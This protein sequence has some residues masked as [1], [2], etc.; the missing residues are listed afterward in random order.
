MNRYGS[1]QSLAYSQNSYGNQ[2][3]GGRFGTGG[4][5]GLGMNRFNSIQK[6]GPN[7]MG[8]TMGNS[9]RPPTG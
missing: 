5:S 2:D 8:R 9:F 6:M 7:Q 1:Q 3:G 4:G